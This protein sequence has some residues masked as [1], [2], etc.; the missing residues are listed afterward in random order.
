M[1][2]PIVNAKDRLLD[3]NP[4]T[5]PDVSGALLNWFQP[6][7]FVRVTTAVVRFSAKKTLDR[8]ES[9][10]V[11]QP[12]TSRQLAMKPE[13]ERAWSWFTMHTLPGIDLV[14]GDEFVVPNLVDGDKPYRVMGQK[15]WKQYGYVEF[16]VVQNYTEVAP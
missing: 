16:E 11:I 10:G 6:L 15:E 7:I 8:I 14:P 9:Q 13:G 2:Q 1:S 12:F 3:A 4:G 5:L